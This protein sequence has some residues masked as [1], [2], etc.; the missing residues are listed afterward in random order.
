VTDSSDNSADTTFSLDVVYPYEIVLIPPKGRTRAGSTVPL[1]WMYLEN[2]VAIDSSLFVVGVTWEKADDDSCLNLT[3]PAPDTN[4]SSFSDDAD[5]GN[6][7]FRY[8]I[9]E[10]LWQFSWQTP[11]Q[12]GWHKLSISPPGGDVEGAWACINLR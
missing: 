5:S 9:E 3:T 8:S 12:T 6:S 10:K 11:N 2:N 7:D 1:D 4:G